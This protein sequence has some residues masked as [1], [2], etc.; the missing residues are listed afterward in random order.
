MGWLARSRDTLV[1]LGSLLAL[2]G[3]ALHDLHLGSS[4]TAVEREGL[5]GV[6]LGLSIAQVRARFDV[7]TFGDFGAAFGCA[8]PGLEWVARPGSETTVR[9]AR[10]EFHM[11]MLA[12]MRLRVSE[13]DRAAHGPPLESAHLTVLGRHGAADG[14]TAIVWLLRE[15]ETHAAEVAELQ[16]RAVVRY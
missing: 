9:R 6:R 12:A 8:E 4:A 15:C 11:G 1:I 13:Q 5:H 16:G 7:A 2:L 14:S 3:F 10:F